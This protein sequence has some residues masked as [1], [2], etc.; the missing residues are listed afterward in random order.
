MP[1]EPHD[2]P[3]T[4]SSPHTRAP[5]SGTQPHAHESHFPAALHVR[6]PLSP[7]VHVHVSF[8]PVV[9]SVIV[10]SSGSGCF[11]GHATA[12]TAKASSNHVFFISRPIQQNS[13]L[14]LG[15][16]WRKMCAK[17]EFDDQSR[18]HRGPRNFG[19][20]QSRDGS[21]NGGARARSRNSEIRCARD[22]RGTTAWHVPRARRRR[23]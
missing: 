9:P 19:G 6:S 23:T 12:R 13:G 16:L 11:F 21:R 4:G 20:R 14:W 22:P 3:Q 1:H 7:P 15:Y 17:L 2:V 8:A 5:H 18:N 10:G